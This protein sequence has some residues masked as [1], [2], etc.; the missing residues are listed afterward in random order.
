MIHEPIKIAERVLRRDLPPIPVSP[1]PAAY[2][3]KLK[4][5]TFSGDIGNYKQFK[6]LF[7]HFT[8][9]LDQTERLYQLVESMQRPA[10]RKKIKPCTNTTYTELGKFLMKAM[11]MTTASWIF[12]Y[13]I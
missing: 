4:F 7:I 13:V 11:G 9:H 1:A 5:P 6:E 2:M 10:E 12:F 8:K 3:Q